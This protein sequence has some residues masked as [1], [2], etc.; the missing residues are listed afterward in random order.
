ME[1]VG[2]KLDGHQRVAA[3]SEKESYAPTDQR[4]L[5]RRPPVFLSR[6]RATDFLVAPLPDRVESLKS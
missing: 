1:E 2:R 4:Y 6:L 5:P 3:I